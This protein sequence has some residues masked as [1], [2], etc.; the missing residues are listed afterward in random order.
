VRGKTFRRSDGRLT[1][2]H[3]TGVA[4]TSQEDHRSGRQLVKDGVRSAIRDDQI[5]LSELVDAIRKYRKLLDQKPLT[6]QGSE[7]AQAVRELNWI[8]HA[9]APSETR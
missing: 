9:L 1:G 5:A 8:E 2:C 4:A 6:L 7:Y 3:R